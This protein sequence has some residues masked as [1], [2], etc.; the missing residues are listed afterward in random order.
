MIGP[1]GSGKSMFAKRIPSTMP[2]PTQDE[3]LEILSIH[4]AAGQTISGE[5][6]WDTCPFRSPHHT[7]PDVALLGGGTI[8]GPGEVSLA[9]HGVLFLDEPPEFK[10]SALEVLR[11]PLEEGAVAISRSAGKSTCRAPSCSSPR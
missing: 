1:P 6:T 11:Q 4:S 8:H 7:V 9:H 10:R 5:M 3:H 2:E